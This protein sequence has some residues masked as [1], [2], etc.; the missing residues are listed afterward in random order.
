MCVC[1]ECSDVR[2]RDMD[3]EE[4]RQE[5]TPGNEMCKEDTARKVAAKN[6]E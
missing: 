3:I 2:S 4:K 1:D 5:S 6:Q